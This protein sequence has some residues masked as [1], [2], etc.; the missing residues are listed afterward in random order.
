MSGARTPGRGEA[1]PRPATQPGTRPAEAPAPAGKPI[2]LPPY[3]V[4]LHNDDVNTMDHV[5]HALLAS[6]PELAPEEAVQVMLTAHEEGVALV[7][8]CPL[9][10]AE[11]YRERLEREGLTATIE[12]A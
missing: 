9:E 7:I 1:A 5:V 2:T 10:R 4:M 3:A 6:V 12:R 11:L 8:T